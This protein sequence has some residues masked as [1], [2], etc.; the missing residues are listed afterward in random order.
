MQTKFFAINLAAYRKK[1]YI[2]AQKECMDTV[3]SEKIRNFFKTQPVDKAW[4]VGSFSRGEERLD[5]DVDIIV[6][7]VPGTRMGLQFFKMN[8][9]LEDLLCRQGDRQCSKGNGRQATAT[10]HLP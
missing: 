2:C 7:L 3:V 1:M 8:I 5:S 4:G 9:E 10:C 6:R